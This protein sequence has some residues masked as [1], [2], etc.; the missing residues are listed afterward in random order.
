MGAEV[1]GGAMVDGK[2]VVTDDVVGGAVV[3]TGVVVVTNNVVVVNAVVV[4]DGVVLVIVLVV[5]GGSVGQSGSTH[6]W[7]VAGFS[8]PAQNEAST[9]VPFSVRHPT[10]RIASPTPHVTEH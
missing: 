1:V 9:I 5:V 10:T 3:G 2:T 7:T 6:R 4:V 8:C